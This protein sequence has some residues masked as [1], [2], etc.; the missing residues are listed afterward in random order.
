MYMSNFT[1]DW[2]IDCDIMKCYLDAVEFY[3]GTESR[4]MNELKIKDSGRMLYGTTWR[5]FLRYHPTLGHKEYL[6]RDPINPNLGLTKIRC[7]EPYLKEV[8]KEFQ[9]IYFPDFE[10][11]S[12]QLTKNFQI[13]KHK[14]SQNVGESVLVAF[15]NYKGGDTV[16]NFEDRV[17]SHDARKHP[18][19][20][21]GSIY[22]H[23]VEKF[24]D[25]DRYSLVFFNK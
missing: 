13:K 14:D 9:S 7:Q 23:W 25:G 18:L 22:E 21:N 10:Y 11:N 8:F 1:G 6:P 16:I 4:K 19:R 24:W 17:E 5:T 3:S 20:F 15:G 2:I 12:V